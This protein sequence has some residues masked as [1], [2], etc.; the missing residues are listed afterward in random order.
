MP[1]EA[2]V[3]WLVDEGS[4]TET[5]LVHAQARLVQLHSRRIGDILVD[6][7][8]VSRADMSKVLAEQM[9]ELGRGDKPMPIGE[10]LIFAEKITRAQL[11]EGLARQTRLR[12]MGIGDVLVELGY[13]TEARFRQAISA[14]MEQ[15]AA[16]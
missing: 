12:N 2:L 3:A 7:C 8:V 15:V 10:H 11:S 4:I 5:Q 1:K 14:Q 6:M 13:L 9:S 16:R